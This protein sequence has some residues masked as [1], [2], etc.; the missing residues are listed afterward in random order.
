VN[1]AI[2]DR[3]PVKIE[4]ASMEN[5][6]MHGKSPGVPVKSIT[7]NGDHARFVHKKWWPRK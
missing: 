1:I 6:H 3:Y 2:A 4:L 7:P 5:M